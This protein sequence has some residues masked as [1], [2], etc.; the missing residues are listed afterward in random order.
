MI[1]RKRPL[2]KLKDEETR[3]QLKELQEEALG[4]IIDLGAAPTSASPL[5][6]DNT[7]GKYGN[8]IF[9]RIGS[10]IYKHTAD[11]VIAIS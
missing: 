2:D 4:N 11:E 5:L 9:W 1:T 6:D 3:E 8:D 7:V 10:N